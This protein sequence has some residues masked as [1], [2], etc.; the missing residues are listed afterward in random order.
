VA[1]AA[2]NNL[3]PL[4]RE[5][6][7]VV[8]FLFGLIHGF[9]F[10]NVLTDLGLSESALALS[11][12]GFNLG[13]EAGQLAIVSVFLP[14]AYGLRDSWFYRGL[15]LKF[16]STCIVVVASIWMSERLFN[17]KFLPF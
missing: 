13:V 9:G 8:A 5:R 11:L 17:L 10:A 4:F 7:W 12:V 14:V 16:G 6:A 15:T 1:L 3:Y 2:L